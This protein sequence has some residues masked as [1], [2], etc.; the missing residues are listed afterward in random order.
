MKCRKRKKTEN[1]IPRAAMAN[2]EKVICQWKCVVCHSKNSSFVKNQEPGGCISNLGWK[3]PLSE[4]PLFD[5]FF[6]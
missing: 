4:I 3:I 2:E 6:F 5:D 1:K